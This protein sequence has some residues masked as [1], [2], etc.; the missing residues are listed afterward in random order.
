MEIWEYQRCLGALGTWNLELGL[1]M[2]GYI[3]RLHI[4][5]ETPLFVLKKMPF[6]YMALHHRLTY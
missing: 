5:H 3:L 4:Y 2:A 1:K 6:I